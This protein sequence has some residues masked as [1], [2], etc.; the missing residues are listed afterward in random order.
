MSSL[1]IFH[2]VSFFPTVDG[3]GFLS[4]SIAAVAVNKRNQHSVVRTQLPTTPLGQFDKWRWVG[5]A[6][7]AEK[8]YRGHSWYNPENTGEVHAAERFNDAP[9]PG[10]AWWA[11]GKN[12]VVGEVEALTRAK[13][14]KWANVKKRRNAAEYGTLAWEGSTFDADVTSRNRLMGVAMAAQ[15]RGGPPAE[16]MWRLAD[17]SS[18]RLTTAQLADVNAALWQ[19]AV[20]AHTRAAEL[21][22]QINACTSLRDLAQL[23]AETGWPE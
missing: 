15:Q 3:D 17:N 2:A 23:D 20:D 16:I 9:P 11:P 5:R 19:R 6:W 14:E 1:P 7:V 12:R 18:R 8:D 22:S 13:D 21:R 4:G 10:W